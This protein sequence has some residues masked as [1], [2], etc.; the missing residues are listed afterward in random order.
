MIFVICKIFGAFGVENLQCYI[1]KTFM[2]W[3]KIQQLYG[4]SFYEKNNIKMK[5]EILKSVDKKAKRVT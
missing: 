4:K 5:I 3:T 1:P 2:K